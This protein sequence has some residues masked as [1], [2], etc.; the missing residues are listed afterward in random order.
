MWGK[1]GKKPITMHCSLKLERF[2]KA[3]LLTLWETPRLLKMHH[4]M[5]LTLILT[6]SRVWEM[7]PWWIDYS[8]PYSQ[9]ENRFCFHCT[10]NRMLL[11][12][13]ISA[14]RWRKKINL[15]TCRCL[16]S[17][18]ICLGFINRNTGPNLRLLSL[19]RV[20]GWDEMVH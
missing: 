3:M 10:V 13:I 17:D 6:L 20:L 9:V 4:K 19:W 1:A 8:R 16:C 15:G 14:K 2:L 11:Y 5:A 7:A 18:C 12:C